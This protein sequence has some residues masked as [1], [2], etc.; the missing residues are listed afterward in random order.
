MVKG[1]CE[2]IAVYEELRSQMRQED[3]VLYDTVALGVFTEAHRAL[4]KALHEESIN[5]TASNADEFADKALNIQDALKDYERLLFT[6]DSSI[7]P[8]ISRL[9]DLE[10]DDVLDNAFSNF[11]K[12]HL[13]FTHKQLM[14]YFDE[15]YSERTLLKYIGN[16]P[17]YKKRM[18]F[19]KKDIEER[20]ADLISNGIVLEPRAKD[21]KAKKSAKDKFISMPAVYAIFAGSWNPLV[22]Y[23]EV[24]YIAGESSRVLRELMVIEEAEANQAGKMLKLLFREGN[25]DNFIANFASLLIMYYEQMGEPRPEFI[26]ETEDGPTV[27]LSLTDSAYYESVMV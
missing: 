27:A 25:A 8:N 10:S 13:T 1:K 2:D 20:F 17:I 19:D 7:Q 14:A 16:V 18:L 26:I 11:L 4:K 24:D 3:L 23:P 12:M 15:R 5:V 21:A 22:I 9:I 6:L